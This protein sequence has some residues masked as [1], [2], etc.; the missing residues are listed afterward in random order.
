MQIG[1]T[2]KS[3]IILKQ[4]LI[5]MF[6]RK[7]PFYIVMQKV[8]ARWWNCNKETFDQYTIDK[9]ALIHRLN[10]PQ[11]DIINLLIGGIIKSSLPYS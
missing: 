2:L 3:W 7:L 10:F 9:V 1:H 11:S 8:E 6:D 4:E 5:K